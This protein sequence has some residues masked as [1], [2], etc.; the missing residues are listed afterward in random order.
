MFGGSRSPFG[1]RGLGGGGGDE[2]QLL[3]LLGQTIA[4]GAPASQVE[5]F[6]QMGDAGMTMRRLVNHTCPHF[7]CTLLM[8]VAN[9]EDDDDESIKVAE[10]LVKY[11]ADVNQSDTGEIGTSPLCMSADFGRPKYVQWL[12]DRGARINH[13][14]RPSPTMPI[15]LAAEKNHIEC[16]AILA[17][18]AIRRPKDPVRLATLDAPSIKGVT[19]SG[20]ALERGHAECLGALAMAGADLR[21]C[22]SCYFTIRE[23]SLIDPLREIQPHASM[24]HAILSFTTL[25]CAT[26]QKFSTDLKACSRCRVAHYCSRECQT[27]DWQPFHKASCKKLR[28]GQD[29]VSETARLPE[30]KS[31]AFGF[32]LPFGGDDF[33]TGYEDD[34]SRGDADAAAVWE[35]NAGSRGS[36]NWKRYPIGVEERIESLFE[37]GSPRFMYRPGNSDV[38]GM[39]ERGER[40]AKA[41]RS[42]ATNYI[43]FHDMLEREFYTGAI[44][45]VR[46]NGTRKPPR[47][48]SRNSMF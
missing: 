36:P 41:P 25:Q 33:E 18:A 47:R 48:S 28:K 7:N 27:S 42:V 1:G 4:S 6:F 32:E 19:P 24:L 31:E 39:S 2:M 29:M 23:D 26:C 15:G 22:F 10:V 16:V 14:V 44:R 9:R 45:A 12:V 8:A 43:Y 35:Y 38:D 30:P 46:R 11:G 37:M 17:K 13:H 5:S 34:D 40:S 3:F 20:Q 21:R